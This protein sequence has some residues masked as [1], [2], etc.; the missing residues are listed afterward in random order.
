M[1][2]L[3]FEPDSR[4]RRIDSRIV[5]DH[6]PSLVCLPASL[7][8]IDPRAFDT[9]TMAYIDRGWPTYQVAPGNTHFAMAGA[10]L[11]NFARTSAIRHFDPRAPRDD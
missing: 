1:L 4:L 11:V 8:Y 2:H 6:S 7:E 10:A 9:S 5:D 3:T